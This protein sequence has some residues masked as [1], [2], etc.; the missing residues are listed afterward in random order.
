MNNVRIAHAARPD[1]PPAPRFTPDTPAPVI[2]TVEEMLVAAWRARQFDII[3][4][5][6]NIC[7]GDGLKLAW[8]DPL[9]DPD[10]DEALASPRTGT[11]S[12]EDE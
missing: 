11:S 8:Y 10:G 9:V 5:M 2:D 1:A 4:S 12:G 3:I 7:T 6:I